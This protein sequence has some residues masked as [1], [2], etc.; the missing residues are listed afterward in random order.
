MMSNQIVKLP[1]ITLMM[2]LGAG[3]A[4]ILF[5]LAIVGLIFGA[6]KELFYY[7]SSSQGFSTKSTTFNTEPMNVLITQE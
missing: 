2:T 3:L 5:T 1:I 6:L 7:I 4:V